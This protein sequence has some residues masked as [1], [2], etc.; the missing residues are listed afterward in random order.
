[1]GCFT[2]KR[3]R[4]WDVELHQWAAPLIGMS[5]A[6]GDT[7]CISLA[8]QALTIIYGRD[9][10]PFY[11]MRGPLD[12]AKAFKAFGHPRDVIAHAL[13]VVGFHV[14]NEARAGDFLFGEEA[15]RLPTTMVGLGR[16]ILHT[17][18]EMGVGLVSLFSCPENV[19]VL[20]IP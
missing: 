17:T 14:R 11:R 19:Q 2:V 8:R 3:L 20:R 12:A 16:S 4:N 5:F 9:P 13:G 10:L 7:D 1:M 15:N 18:P 6:W